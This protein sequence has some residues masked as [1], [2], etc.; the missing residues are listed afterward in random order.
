MGKVRYFF[1][2]DIP[3][4]GANYLV[5]GEHEGRHFDPWSREKSV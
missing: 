1:V 5:T 4:R 2:G 3:P